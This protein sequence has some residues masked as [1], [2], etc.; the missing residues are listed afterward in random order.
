MSDACVDIGG[1]AAHSDVPDVFV[2]ANSLPS[3]RGLLLVDR[4]IVALLLVHRFFSEQVLVVAD[5][6]CVHN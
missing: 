2:N 6:R 1:V 5:A 4:G 3:W